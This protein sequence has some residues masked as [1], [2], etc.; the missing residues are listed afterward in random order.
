MKHIRRF[1]SMDNMKVIRLLG[2]AA[3]IV[4]GLASLVSGF[5][6]EKKMEAQVEECVE[7]KMKSLNEEKVK[8]S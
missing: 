6:D 8:E 1:Y 3:T 7:K 5:V 2:Y 4:G